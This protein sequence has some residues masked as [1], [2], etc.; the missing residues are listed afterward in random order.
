MYFKSSWCEPDKT[1]YTLFKS[2]VNASR[3]ARR[4]TALITSLLLVKATANSFLVMKIIAIKTTPTKK[5][6]PTTTITENFAALGRPAPSS[7]ETL[8]L[9]T[10]ITSGISNEILYIHAS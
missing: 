1:G 5:V 10:I 7:F 2:I 6:V 8:T 9:S 4:A 3:G